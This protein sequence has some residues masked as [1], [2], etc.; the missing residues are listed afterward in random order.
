MMKRS[1]EPKDPPIPPRDPQ[2]DPQRDPPKDPYKDP[3]DPNRVPK[4]DRNEPEIHPS[5]RQNP[6][7]P[8]KHRPNN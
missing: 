3:P 5:D 7:E 2:R 6:N 1:Y 8:N 4:R